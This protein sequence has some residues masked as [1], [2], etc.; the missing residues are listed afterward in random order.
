[1]N[2]P[3]GLGT[4]WGMDSFARF[5]A[6]DSELNMYNINPS[7]A[8]K[9]NE[10]FAIAA[11][12]DYYVSDLNNKQDTIIG[13]ALGLAD[14]STISSMDLDVDGNAFGWNAAVMYKIS[15]KHS[16]VCPTGA[17][18]RRISTAIWT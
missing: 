2:V 3:F 1:M 17:R 9:V 12:V 6:P 10:N 15:E 16:W 13:P 8:Y 7:V 18:S 4:D 11:G 14:T 5:V